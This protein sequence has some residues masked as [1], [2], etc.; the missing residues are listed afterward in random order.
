[1]LNL[2]KRT[3]RRRR[4]SWSNS[5]RKVRVFLDIVC[6]QREHLVYHAAAEIRRLAELR[7]AHDVEIRGAG[8]TET[9]AERGTACLFNVDQKFRG[10]VEAYAGVERH[11][12]R[13][14]F[15]VMRAE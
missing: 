14:G 8:H 11:D 5:E 2:P 1:M 10:I 6:A 9:R 3:S 12:A 13:G 4:G 15:F 7:I